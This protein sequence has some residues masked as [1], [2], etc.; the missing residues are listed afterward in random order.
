L[1]PSKPALEATPV[2][3][4]EDT[5][6]LELIFSK[7]PDIHVVF[8]TNVA[9]LALARALKGLARI[10]TTVGPLERTRTVHLIAVPFSTIRRAVLRRE[11]AVALAVPLEPLARVLASVGVA[12]LA[13]AVALAVDDLALEDLPPDGRVVLLMF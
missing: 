8:P 2:V 3:V 12:V 10:R 6:A 7:I 9:A 5:N 13:D 11:L 4:R 1:I